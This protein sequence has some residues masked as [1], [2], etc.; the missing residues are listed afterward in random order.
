MFRF[1]HRGF[2]ILALACLLIAPGC[3]KK[4]IA[5]GPPPDVPVRVAKATVQ[6]MPVQIIAIGNVEAFASVSIKPMVSGELETIRF[7]EG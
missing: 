2:L 5:A 4:E 1:L 6:T 3:E 7:E